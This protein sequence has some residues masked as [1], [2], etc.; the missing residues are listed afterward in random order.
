MADEK[1]INLDFDGV[2][3]DGLDDDPELAGMDLSAF[4]NV[5]DTIDKPHLKISTKVFKEVLK[6]AKTICAAGGRDVIS[7]ALCLRSEGDKVVCSMTDFDVYL[8]VKVER[9]NMENILDEAV[10]VPTDILIKLIKAVPVNTIIFKDGDTLKIRLYGGDIA[11]ETYNV[12]VSKFDFK[13]PVHKVSSVAS[14]E[15]YSTMKDFTPIVTAAVAPTERRIVCEPNKAYAFYM[16]GIMCSEK[17]YA[18]MDL[19]VKDIGVLKTLTVNLDEDL[20]VSRTDEGVKV[21]RQVITGQ[22]FSYAFLVSDSKVS[23][24]LKEGIGSV[25]TKDGV[26]VDFIQLYKIV[27]VASELPYAIGKVGFNYV[28]DGIGLTVKTKKGG[29]SPFVLNGS[30]VGN[31]TPLS[32]ELVVS[33]KLLRT[34]LRSFATQSSVLLTLSPKG[35]G[36]S[37]DDYMSAIYPETK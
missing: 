27:E 13:D 17:T 7:K 21:V 10:V 32:E 12:D 8:Q 25:V 5:D 9:L 23:E 35:M 18:D 28:D 20:D 16:W 1:D 19:K 30:K 15:L 3:L 31:T 22:N 37:C 6:V 29:D 2:N 36:I 26:Y 24:T 11:L 33:A 14:K 34:F 4:G